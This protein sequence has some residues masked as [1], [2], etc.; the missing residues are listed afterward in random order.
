MKRIS[1]FLIIIFILSIAVGCA[2]SPSSSNNPII[3]IVNDTGFAV[4]YLYIS[5]ATDNHWGTDRLGPEQ[6]IHHG[7]TVSVQLPHPLSVVD[8]YDIL[9]ITP[10]ND[11]YAKMDVTVIPGSRL[12]FNIRDL[13]IR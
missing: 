4:F 2:T 13:V 7:Q 6:F 10:D 9:L 5:P 3:L 1:I 8:K 11:R 12:V